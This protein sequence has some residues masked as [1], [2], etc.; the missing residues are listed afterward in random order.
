MD[1]QALISQLSLVPG[2]C[3][4]MAKTYES[5][6]LVAA[7]AGR[8]RSIGA[9]L[10]F[11][12][13]PERGISPHRIRSVLFFFLFVGVL[14]VVHLLHAEGNVSRQLVG[15]D[16]GA[17]MLPQLLIPAGAFHLGRLAGGGDSCGWALLGTTS[18]PGVA[19]GEFEYAELSH[20]LARYASAEALN[21]EFAVATPAPPKV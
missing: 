15:A 20:L 3:G 9:A 12:I 19:E 14:L 11:L 16:F 13:T 10:Y 7:N 17:G 1:A 5:P 21:N 2:T 18:W 4:Y 6:L 8:Q